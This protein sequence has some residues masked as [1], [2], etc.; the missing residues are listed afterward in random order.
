M[1]SQWFVDFNPRIMEVGDCC[2]N[3]VTDLRIYGNAREIR[4]N[5]GS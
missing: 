3:R 1:C 4:A 5:A 2:R